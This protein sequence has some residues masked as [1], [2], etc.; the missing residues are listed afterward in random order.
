MLMPDP[1]RTMPMLPPALFDDEHC[2]AGHGE[3]VEGSYVFQ[4]QCPA[5]ED[6]AQLIVEARPGVALNRDPYGRDGPRRSE[7]KGEW[8]V[9]PLAK[10]LKGV[11]SKIDANLQNH[12]VPTAEKLDA[13]VS[14]LVATA[15]RQ[16]KHAPKKMR[17]TLQGLFSKRFQK[18]WNFV[19]NEK[20]RTTT[21]EELKVALI[22]LI[23]S[24]NSEF[25]VNPD[26]PAQPVRPV[27]G[28]AC[29]R[30]LSD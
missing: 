30:K 27:R 1:I 16:T 6:L 7:V 15:H 8:S 13:F 20:I 19:R 5:S 21:P 3:K 10:Y 2:V 11:A 4:V 14:R 26:L 28:G 18:F 29:F 23:E 17:H 22:C 9:E 24:L 12:C 25:G